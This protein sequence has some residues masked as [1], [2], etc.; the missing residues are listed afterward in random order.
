MQ[1]H[2]DDDDT[3]A[4][5]RLEGL[6]QIAAFIGTKPRRTYHLI[7]TQQLPG[8]AREGDKLIGSKEIL[9]RYWRDLFAADQEPPGQPRPSRPRLNRGAER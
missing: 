2:D 9:R 3:I 7:Q 4:D 1:M 8:V 6:E 5:D